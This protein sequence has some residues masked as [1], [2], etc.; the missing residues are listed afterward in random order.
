LRGKGYGCWRNSKHRGS[1]PARLLREL[2][3][4]NEARALCVRYRI[5]APGD[6]ARGPST[7]LPAETVRRPDTLAWEQ[8][9]GHY[10]AALDAR[11]AA[12]LLRRGF[13]E[14]DLLELFEGWGLKCGRAGRY[15]G[16]L[17]IPYYQHNRPVWFTARAITAAD[18][19][20]KSMPHDQAVVDPK[21]LLFHHDAIDSPG[22]IILCEGPLDAIKVSMYGPLPGVGLSTNKATPQQLQA[23]TR[24]QRV[25]IITDNDQVGLGGTPSIAETGLLLYHDLLKLG[26]SVRAVPMPRGYKDLG[27]IP[28]DQFDAALPLEA[29]TGVHA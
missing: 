20:Y 23:L 10:N 4:E 27:D 7:V 29:L 14:S 1:H 11:F 5:G 12:Y 22:G 18:I 8:G 19:R 16:R 3:G 13:D 9:I 21:A 26:V 17:I 2:V 25:F 6:R 28:F 24:A 15:S